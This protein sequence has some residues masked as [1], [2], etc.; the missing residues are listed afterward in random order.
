MKHLTKEK[1]CQL[2]MSPL[3]VLYLVASKSVRPEQITERHI[4]RSMEYGLTWQGPFS[5]R[6]FELLRSHLHEFYAEFPRNFGASFEDEVR[7]ELVS[8]KQLLA[9]LSGP[10]EMIEDFKSAL[11]NL[12]VFVAEGGAFRKEIHDE[13]MLA[14]AAWVAD[15]FD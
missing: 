13:G 5:H 3:Y 7:A 6:I 10:S 14:E 15:L 12:A 9:N 2:G 4:M 1:I 11:K 8:V